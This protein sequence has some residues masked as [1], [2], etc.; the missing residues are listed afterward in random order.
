M[1]RPSFLILATIVP[2]PSP[3]GII[4]LLFPLALMYHFPSMY[5]LNECIG[6]YLTMRRKEKGYVT[7]PRLSIKQRKEI[8]SADRDV[9]SVV[10]LGSPG[11]LKYGVKV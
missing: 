4:A 7:A 5:L 10:S 9:A 3:R 6:W 1:I 2:L 11:A 8:Q